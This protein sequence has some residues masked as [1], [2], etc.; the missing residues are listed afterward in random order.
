M[1]EIDNK[2]TL[3][4]KN[5]MYQQRHRAKLKKAL[6]IDKFKEEQRTYMSEYR[7]QRN[8]DEG[9][10]KPE[11][12]VRIKEPES[13]KPMIYDTEI[14][15]KPIKENRKMNKRDEADINL[16]RL[17]LIKKQ[18]TDKSIENYT[19]NISIIHRLI[20]GEALGGFR[21]EIIKALKGQKYDK[22]LE[23]EFAYFKANKLQDTIKTMKQKY[24]KP[25]TFKAYINSVTAILG[26]IEGFDTEYSYISD[27][28]KNLQAEYTVQRDLNE[29]TQ[30]E[31]DIID[32]V[33]FDDKSIMSNIKKLKELRDKV[34]YAM[35]MY[36]PRRL[37]MRTLRIRYNSDKGTDSGNYIIAY[38]TRSG[39]EY[40]LIFNEYKTAQTYHKQRYTV[41]KT[42]QPILEEYIET[43]KFKTDEYLFHMRRDKRESFDEGR[44]STEFS[45]IF[46]KVYDVRIKNQ[47][48]RIAYATYWTPKS[49]N[50]AEKKKVSEYYL[51]HDLQTNEQYLKT[52]LKLKE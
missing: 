17:K 37:E 14:I 46:E 51:S 32:K 26:R 19:Q 29:A 10:V 38:D 11:P 16:Q 13:L 42:I 6:G 15:L 36:I 2:A 47:L 9:Y 21:Q 49:K 34:L 45:T 22:D 18:L 52:N 41:P 35:Y 25:N 30:E 23:S 31:L 40:E 27:I 24:P 5:R 43:S 1:S 50:L 33:K 28:G 8:I 7:A 3:A 39:F 48:L 44:F 12:V 4:E 20:T